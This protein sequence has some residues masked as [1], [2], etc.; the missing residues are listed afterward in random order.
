MEFPGVWYEMHLI[1]AGLDV[2]GVTIPGTPFVVIGH[3]QRIAWGVTNTG[4]DVQDLYIERV[5]VA[6]RR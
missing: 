3:N 1:A 2:M 4:A 6:R 5:D